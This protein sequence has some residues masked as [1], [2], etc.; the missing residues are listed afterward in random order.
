M[1][2]NNLALKKESDPLTLKKSTDSELDKFS[3]LVEFLEEKSEMLISYHLRNSFRL[4]KFSD[5][6]ENRSAC[7][8]ELE[9]IGDDEEAKVNSL[10]GFKNLG[11][12]NKKDGYYQLLTSP[13]SNHF[14]RLS[15]L[16]TK[17]L[18]N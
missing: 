8:I 18:S 7:H 14:Q 3:K 16:I 15:N 6:D 11:T 1:Q 13:V 12:N 10:E 9:N 2:N 4:V 5:I 17:K